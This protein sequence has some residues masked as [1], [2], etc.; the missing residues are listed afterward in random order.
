MLTRPELD[1]VVRL[2]Q[3]RSLSLPFDDRMWKYLHGRQLVRHLPWALPATMRHRF[4]V[5]SNWCRIGVETYVNRQQLSAAKLIGGTDDDEDL[6]LIRDANNFDHQLAMFNRDRCTFGRAIMS[7]FPGNDG[8]PRIRVES[9]REMALEIDEY[10]EVVS[11][12]AR[13]YG[14]DLTRATL[15]MLADERNPSRTIHLRRERYGNQWVEVDRDEYDGP[16]PLFLHLNRRESGSWAGESELVD[17][18]PLVDSAAQSLTLMGASANA[19]GFPKLILSGVQTGDFTKP[20]GTLQPRVESYLDAMTLLR[21]ADAKAFQMTPADLKNFDTSLDVLGRQAGAVTG[22]PPHYFGIMPR[23]N[24]SSEGALQ[25][26]EGALVERIEAA[27]REVGATLGWVLA[28]AY[29]LRTGEQVPH[30]QVQ[31]TWHDPAT[32]TYSQRSE[33]I[34]KL[35]TG[36]RPILSREGAWDRLGMSEAEKDKERAYFAAELNDPTIQLAN[37]LMNGSTDAALGN[38]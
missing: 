15:Y 1:A 21:Q 28:Y 7:A 25:F 32:P 31:V 10:R 36:A 19:H 34:F 6:R 4:T 35:T 27:N 11:A 17:L 38:A 22:I 37:S 26:A 24:P 9:P 30:N 12:G 13:F 14:A 33:A 16:L 29:E 20:D 8:M 3:A 18:V 2:E 5:I 23:N